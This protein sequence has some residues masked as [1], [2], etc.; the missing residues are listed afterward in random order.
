[1]E[2]DGAA[3]VVRGVSK[4]FGRKIIAGLDLTIPPGEFYALLGP[5]GVGKT[6]TLRMIA[7]LMPPDTGSISVFGRDVLADPLV[8][9]VLEVHALLRRAELLAL[10]DLEVGDDVCCA[11]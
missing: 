11:A 1:M 2:S 3:L 9:V 4:S 7:G 5:N 8:Q 6:T 10:E